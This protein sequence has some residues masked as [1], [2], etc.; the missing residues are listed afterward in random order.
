M[1]LQRALKELEAMRLQLADFFCEDLGT[2]KMEECFKTFHNFCE[3][4]GQ[5]V[6]DND[7]RRVQEEQ[8]LVRRKQREEQL[9][10][11]RR[12]CMYYICY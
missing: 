2:F 11:K 3:K 5:A 7:K 8:A 4:F 10:L 12:Q 6:K 1:M 9:A